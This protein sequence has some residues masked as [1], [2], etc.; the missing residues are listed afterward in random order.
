[1]K[2]KWGGFSVDVFF[3]CFLVFLAIKTNDYGGEF[4]WNLKV[5]KII[6][7]RHLLQAPVLIYTLEL[8]K[9]NK[10]NGAIL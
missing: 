6:V 1:M 3:F 5:M 2:G 9:T 8:S 4:K 10:Q 7:R